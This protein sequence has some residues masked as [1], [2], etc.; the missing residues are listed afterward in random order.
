MSKEKKSEF[1][2]QMQ[3]MRLCKKHFEKLLTKTAR[4]RAASFLLQTLSEEPEESSALPGTSGSAEALFA[5]S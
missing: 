5:K 3:V 2:L 1:E 4:L